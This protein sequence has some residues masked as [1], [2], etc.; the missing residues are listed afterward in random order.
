MAATDVIR[1]G[2]SRMRPASR[3]AAT[4]SM[5]PARRS[6]AYVT[7]RMEFFDTRPISRIMPIWLNTLSVEPAIQS[8]PSAPVTASG[9]ASSTVNGCSID[10]NCAASTMYTKTSASVNA[11]ASAPPL[12]RNSRD[13]PA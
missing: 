8:A 4:G 6:F 7:S 12:S 9:T 1:I 5:P 13:S 11:K 3:I 10:S 2:R